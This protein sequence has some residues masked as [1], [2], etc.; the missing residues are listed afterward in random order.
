MEIEYI[1]PAGNEFWEGLL[2]RHPEATPFHGAQWARVLSETYGHSSC[3][4]VRMEGGVAKSGWPLL[5]VSSPITGRRGICLP[6]TD[7]CG[8]LLEPNEG[9]SEWF[10]CFLAEGRRRKWRHLELRGG[11][12]PIPEATPSSSFY[13]HRLEI[14]RGEEE[15]LARMHPSV[16]RGIRKAEREGVEVSMETGRDAIL[17]YFELHCLTRRTHGLPPQPLRWF[18]NIHRFLIACGMGFVA[19]GRFGG[20]AVAAAL[21]LVQGSNAVYKYGA[22]DESMQHLRPN[23]LVMWSAIRH[24]AQ[25]GVRGL[26]F[27]RTSI[28]NE[29]LRRFKLCWGA[30]ESMVRY[31]KYRLIPGGFVCDEDRSSGR[32]TMIFRNLPSCIS[33]WAG[34]LMYPHIA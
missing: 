32:H 17:N 30:S 7:E 2:A 27:G 4:A 3:F 28:W 16:R 18:E 10:S 12:P 22:S 14:C 31:Y 34:Q 5:E 9:L 25:R 8:P 33:R 29:G 6:F 13:G 15:L 21:F 19:I 26:D 24:L 1:R 11:G 20:R 23:H